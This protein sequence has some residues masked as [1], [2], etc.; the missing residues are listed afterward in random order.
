MPQPA[1]SRSRRGSA[2]S[3]PAQR[4]AMPHS[5]SPLGVDPADRAGVAVAVHALEL[6]DERRAR[7]SSACRRPPRSG[8]APPRARG[9]VRAVGEHAGDVGG[10]VHDVRQVQ[11]ERRLGHVHRRAVRRQRLAPPSARRTRAPRGP[12]SSGPARAARARSRA[13]SPVRR[14]VPASTREVTRPF[15]R[16]HQHLGR[17][18]D[19]A[20]DAERPAAGV[21]RRRAARSS[22]RGSTGALGAGLEVAASTTFSTS[23]RSIRRDRRRHGAL[24]VGRRS[25]RRPRR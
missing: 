18:A 20:V 25:G 13:S 12:C 2:G 6:A 1:N 4:S 11:H 16:R 22:Q 15:S 24:P 3:T 7:R 9:E 8:A 10:Q 17:G 23:P 19:Q 14:M 5:P 21:A